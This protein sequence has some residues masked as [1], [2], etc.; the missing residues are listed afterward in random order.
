MTLV[1]AVAA[2]AGWLVAS[3][4]GP[5]LF[6]RHMLDAERGPGGMMQHAEQ[7]F[8]SASA[9]TI[10]VALAAAVLTALVAS[11]LLARRIGA[12]LG[13]L[14]AAA[15]QVASGRFDVRLDDPGMGTE[16]DDLADAFNAMAGRL[17]H[18]QELRRR[19][20]AD[21]AHELRTPVATIVAYVDA[22]EDG[23]QDL[24]PEAV[25]V[26]RAQ[27][28]RLTRLATDLSAVTQVESGTLVLDRRRV[29]P[30]LLVDTAVSAVRARADDAGIALVRRVATQ[31][32][33]L[34]VDVDR[35]GQ[36]LAN[37]LDNAIRHTPA[38]GTVTVSAERS[39]A[40]VRLS[41][42]DTGEGIDE[43]HL[44]YV[45]ERFYRADTARDRAHGGSGI[46]LAIAKALV[47][48]H[49]GSVSARSAGPGRGSTFAVDLPA[50][51]EPGFIGS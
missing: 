36:V 11:T 48:A 44:P 39:A 43:E 51:A 46:G 15:G 31:L 45:F 20:M 16:F 21:V 22:L 25:E 9:V 41:V 19:L 18:D 5:T 8:A 7:A 32:P 29:A 35:I 6:H 28:S 47:Q 10:A 24:T 42:D 37:L 14:S 38:G 26:L 50:P 49:G 13:T 34:E 12:S 33:V 17:D 40:G 2:L 30:R 1:L 23:V 4:L 27:T 3:A